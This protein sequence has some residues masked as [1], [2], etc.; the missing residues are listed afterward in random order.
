MKLTAFLTVLSLSSFVA[1]MPISEKAPRGIIPSGILPS[2]AALMDKMFP[3]SGV[4][5]LMGKVD[6][7][8]GVC[9]CRKLS[10]GTWLTDYRIDEGRRNMR[11][12]TW[13]LGRSLRE[14]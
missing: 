4:P 6:G 10:V 12:L 3:H 8:T 7:I 5:E 2:P 13:N 1:A 9:M 14:T 11:H